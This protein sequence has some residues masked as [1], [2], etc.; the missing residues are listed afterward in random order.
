MDHAPTHLSLFRASGGQLS[1]EVQL[2]L[3]NP[4]LQWISWQAPEWLP[5]GHNQPKR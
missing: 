1:L 2:L 3:L 4:L 5:D